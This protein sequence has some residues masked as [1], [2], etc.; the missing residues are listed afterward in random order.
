MT[1]SGSWTGN[2]VHQALQLLLQRRLDLVVGRDGEPALGVDLR[3]E[4]GEDGAEPLR[5]RARPDCPRARRVPW[6]GTTP[7]PAL[8]NS[9][10]N[11]AWWVMAQRRKARLQASS[12]VGGGGRPGVVTGGL[13]DGDQF[14]VQIGDDVL[15]EV[16]AAVEVPVERGRRHAHLAGDGAQRQPVD[17][18]VDEHAPGGLLDLT[19]RV[20]TQAIAPADRLHGCFRHRVLAIPLDNSEQC[21][22]SDRR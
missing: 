20:G 17:A 3:D 5:R 4:D 1:P 16:L 21:K 2:F 6:A 8:P 13:E 18:L 15:D 22:Q 7:S 11:S 10:P 9:S 12:W 14:V 19:H